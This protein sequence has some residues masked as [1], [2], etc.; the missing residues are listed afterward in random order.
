MDGWVE[1]LYRY[2]VKGL[3][4]QRMDAVCL[5][6]GRPI[7]FDR[8]FA[9]ARPNGAVTPED[10]KWAKKGMFVML[11]LDERLASVVTHLDEASLRLEARDHQGRLLLEANLAEAAGRSAAERFFQGLAPGLP[12]PPS[13]VQ[14]RGGHFMDKPDGVI[15]LINLATLR[16]LESR[17][18]ERLDP[19]RFR[20]NIYVDGIP[21]W[22]ELDWVG[23]EIGLGTAR[24][25][26][27]R[28]N[29]RCSA[30]NV[31]PATGR[32]DLDIPGALRRS[33][34]HKDLGV[35]LV[36]LSAATLRIGD[37]LAGPG[38]PAAVPPAQ[39]V[40]AALAETGPA[41]RR[42]ICG[43]CYLVYDESRGAPA[44]GVPPGTPFTA[45][46]QGWTCPDCGVGLDRYRA[47]AAPNGA[48]AEAQAGRT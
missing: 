2:P 31:D 23:H 7:P 8:V 3:S 32:R 27:D 26:V 43:G 37:R 48:R 28:R 22:A 35:Y 11:M 36:A 6:E 18:G 44:A 19:L 33:F 47:Y 17:W 24:V 5:A 9:L 12:R 16:D 38:A 30:V 4:A 13:L 39:V 42:F 21:A 15:S 46:P 29:G 34:G 20:A 10:P 1:A 41:P 25:R 45:L 14:A 40:A